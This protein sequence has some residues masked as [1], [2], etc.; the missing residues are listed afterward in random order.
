MSLDYTVT[1]VRW[2]NNGLN[3]DYVKDKYHKGPPTQGVMLWA[4]VEKWYF[5]KVFALPKWAYH[6]LPN[7]RK[8]QVFTFSSQPRFL[9]TNNYGSYDS[10]RYIYSNTVGA[11]WLDDELSTRGTFCIH[12][13]CYSTD[14]TD[15][16][17]D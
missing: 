10:I 13:K 6:L 11:G 16:H 1:M 8:A 14:V 5:F 9:Y 4:G 2:T 17:I 3:Y 15:P 7:K 12:G